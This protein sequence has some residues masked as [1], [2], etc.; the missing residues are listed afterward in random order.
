MMNLQMEVNA[1]P[2]TMINFSNEAQALEENLSTEQGEPPSIT[3]DERGMILD[4]SKACEKYF[5][6]QRRD[7]VWHH[8]SRL[9]PQL[10]GV[11]L[12]KK[13]QFNP[14]LVF[15]CR[16]G[17]IFQAKNIMGDLFSCNLSFVHLEY[18]GK[19]TLRLI[20]NP[21]GGTNIPG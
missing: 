2:V 9:F 11:E 13:G 4:Y 14:L 5:G 15:L 19:P 18:N 3:L 17:K 16:C 10:N 12:V 21:S 20:V 6:Y 1:T 7:L 8:V